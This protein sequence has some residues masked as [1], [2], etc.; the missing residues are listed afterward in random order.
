M[1]IFLASNTGGH[2]ERITLFGRTEKETDLSHPMLLKIKESISPI[3][4]IELRSITN[5]S[6]DS[7]PFSLYEEL[8]SNTLW[9]YPWRLFDINGEKICEKFP[10]ADIRYFKNLNNDNQWIQ[11]AINK[12]LEI[13]DLHTKITPP[14]SS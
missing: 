3:D 9:G 8:K 1:T 13:S 2:N 5:V 14:S 12:A 4:N 11:A 6:G 7:L 10:T